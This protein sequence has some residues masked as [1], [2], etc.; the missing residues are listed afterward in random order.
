MTVPAKTTEIDNKIVAIQMDVF[1]LTPVSGTSTS[2]SG[3]SV[4]RAGI[5]TASF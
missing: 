2:V 3:T 4:S 5:T 1:D